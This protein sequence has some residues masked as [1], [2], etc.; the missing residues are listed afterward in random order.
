MNYRER[1]HHNNTNMG[2]CHNVALANMTE[3]ERKAMS[4]RIQEV[5]D[6]DNFLVEGKI[7]PL[8]A[9]RVEA[10]RSEVVPMDEPDF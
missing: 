1:L 9:A 8:I 6:W 5:L 10:Y 4:A 3:I 7:T 2:N